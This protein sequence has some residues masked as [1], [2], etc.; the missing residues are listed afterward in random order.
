[1]DAQ[2]A[3]LVARGL[4]G[5]DDIASHL[6]ARL[7]FRDRTVIEEV[8]VGL[9]LGPAFGVESRVHHEANG[10]P[11]LRAQTTELRIGVQVG[12]IDFRGQPLG[13]KAPAFR[14][15]VE[16]GLGPEGGKALELLGDGNLHVMAWQPLVI[17][18]DLKLMLWH[19]IHIRQVGVVDARAG[20][21]EGRGVVMLGS[22]I[23]LSEGLHPAHH[24][25]CLGQDP[26]VVWEP[27]FDAF[28][29]RCGLV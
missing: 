18:N 3:N 10:P 2:H 15:G 14:I 23:L 26:E 1:M 12:A 22:A 16:V 6:G 9:V 7:R 19:G 27:C 4:P 5:H 25:V 13:V 28:Y 29:G 21:V 17:G 20:A 24:E 8:G 11:H